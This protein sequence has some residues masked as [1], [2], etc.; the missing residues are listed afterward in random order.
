MNIDFLSNIVESSDVSTFR[1]IA[2]VFLRSVGYPKAFLSDGPYDGG[3]DFFVHKDPATGIETAFQLSI[4]KDW[5]KKLL[6]D[7]R[8]AKI[9]Y[10]T[11]SAFIFMSKRRIPL[12]SIQKVNTSLI[13]SIGLTATH[14]DNQA[15]A[16]EFIEKNLVP[17]LYELVGIQLTSEDPPKYFASPKSEATAALLIFSSDSSDFR[18][19]MLENL[20]S[21]ELLEQ[22]PVKESEFVE[23]F[24]QRHNFNALQAIDVARHI[25][26]GIENGKFKK[27]RSTLEITD[28]QKARMLGIRSLTRGEFAALKTSVTQFL[29]TM[30]SEI[31]NKDATAILKGLLEL[32]LALWRRTSPHR[33]N[34]SSQKADETYHAIYTSLTSS[35]GEKEAKRAMTALAEIVSRSTFAKNIASSEL[36]YSMLRTN[37]QQVVSA[38]GGH[39]GMLVIF[40]TPVA[41]PLLCGLLFDPIGDHW[42]YSARLLIELLRQHKFTAVIANQYLEEC[43]AHLIDCCRNYQ[44][45]LLAGEDLSFSTNAFASHYSQ[46]IKLGAG[47]P[48]SFDVYIKT[49]GSPP[50]RQ[51]S[52]LSDE[53]FF[54]VRDKLIL[55]TRALFNRYGINSLNL[56]D[57]RYYK[58]EAELSKLSTTGG[59][60]RAGM[61]VTHDAQVIGYLEGTAVEA[62]VVKVLCTWDSV[63]FRYNPNWETYCVMNPAALTDLTS[64]ARADDRNVPMAQLID[65]V[66]MQSEASLKNSAQVWDELVRIE[67]GNLSD[68]NLLSK[69]SNFRKD[70]VTNHQPATDIEPTDVRSKWLQWKGR[71]A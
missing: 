19:E 59:Q 67:K 25:A 68:A 41:I 17:R 7:I 44:A 69:A 31:P 64:V 39:K 5:K 51:F 4:E 53:F 43:A 32:S 14:Y 18:S 27:H 34:G 58:I 50:G 49:F 8:K 36:F 22:S 20:L 55:S 70:Y 9:N 6:Q 66:W 61:L 56:V 26:R 33:A 13:Q 1:T 48:S 46:L 45:L 35:L 47:A 24:L 10:P 52:D 30:N 11:I 23:G 28:S 37:S 3:S 2:S 29:E 42:A 71:N 12:H 21:A 63:H 16:T 40:D 54:S 62:G 57:S 60:S 15:I 65:Y 38:L